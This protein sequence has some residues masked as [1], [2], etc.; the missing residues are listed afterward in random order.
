MV[1]GLDGL[2]SY[3]VLKNG[4]HMNLG[5]APKPSQIKEVE[6]PGGKLGLVST[7][8]TKATPVTISNGDKFT[9]GESHNQ[10][11][12]RK[13]SEG[14]ATKKQ[15]QRLVKLD[16]I[17][18]SKIDNYALKEG[19]IPTKK[20]REESRVHAAQRYTL[21]RNISEIGNL[22][23]SKGMG[24]VA[25]VHRARLIS[26]MRAVQLVIKGPAGLNLGV[27]TGDDLKLIE[28]MAPSLSWNTNAQNVIVGEFLNNE[29]LDQIILKTYSDLNKFIEGKTEDK[30]NSVGYF[31]KGM[32]NEN[33]RALRHKPKREVGQNIPMSGA[34][35]RGEE[36]IGFKKERIRGNKIIVNGAEY[37][38]DDDGFTATRV[39]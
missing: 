27:L 20:E 32:V 35:P 9:F 19:F 38:V 12:R 21:K 34:E 6:L 23:R 29:N 14:S 15:A 24:E 31:R 26:K 25:S 8:G 1:W 16:D 3:P 11:A 7:T 13:L 18:R 10:E 30:L 37:I 22:I 5:P 36:T 17:S 33:N 28:D 4:K 2:N 39:K